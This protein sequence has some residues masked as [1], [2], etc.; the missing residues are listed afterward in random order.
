MTVSAPRNEE[1]RLVRSEDG[2][3]T[4][5]TAPLAARRL[6]FHSRP[7]TGGAIWLPMVTEL[8]AHQRGPAM[9]VKSALVHRCRTGV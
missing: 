5:R 6:E 9:I 4:A 7:A 2:D 1:E 8:L 3:S